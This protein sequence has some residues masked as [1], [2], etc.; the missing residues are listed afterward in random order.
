MSKADRDFITTNISALTLLSD[1]DHTGGNDIAI[2]K[3]ALNLLEITL[4]DINRTADS[5]ESIATSLLVLS[6]KP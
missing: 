5:L 1:A 3:N 6:E 2:T 4:Q